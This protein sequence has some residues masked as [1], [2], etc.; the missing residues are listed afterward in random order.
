MSKTQATGKSIS[1]VPRCTVVIVRD[2]K[3]V[4]PEIGKAFEFTAQEVA[5]IEKSSVKAL[6]PV[7]G[8]SSGALTS[9]A[10]GRSVS[11]DSEI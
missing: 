5:D 1:R 11:T 10:D 7:E 4:V 9:V 3:Q 8:A 2:G 6:Y